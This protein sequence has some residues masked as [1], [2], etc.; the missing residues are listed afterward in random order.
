MTLGATPHQC[1]GLFAVTKL[2]L[3]RGLESLSG[4]DE[5]GGRVS[6]FLNFFLL[7][8]FSRNCSVSAVTP[9]GGFLWFKSY[10][11]SRK[12]PGFRWLLLLG[13]LF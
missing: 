12:P 4:S 6:A 10:S 8:V 11:S 13:A 3:A 1:P 5:P 9:S 2:F 7:L